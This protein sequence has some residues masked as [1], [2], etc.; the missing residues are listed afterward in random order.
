MRLYKILNE[1]EYNVYLSTKNFEGS[2][3]DL[4]DG[5]I[6][7]ST[8]RQMF[9]TMEIHFINQS[10]LFIVALNEKLLRNELKWEPS[11]KSEVFPH[12]Y[13]TLVQKQSVYCVKIKF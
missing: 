10:P 2:E 6:H 11:R 5:F 12:Y 7:L 13:G 3:K 4:E 9:G 8:W 1:E